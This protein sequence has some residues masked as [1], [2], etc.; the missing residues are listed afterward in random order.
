M[1]PSQL[2]TSAQQALKAENR[3]AVAFLDVSPGSRRI[4]ELVE[5]STKLYRS[6]ILPSSAFRPLGKYAPISAR[7]P[8]LSRSRNQVRLDQHRFGHPI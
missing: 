5:S 8:G 6:S 1:F 7:V 2:G 4:Y 3:G